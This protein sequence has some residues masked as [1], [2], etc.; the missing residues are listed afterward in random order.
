MSRATD[1]LKVKLLKARLEAAESLV[2]SFL[3][4]KGIGKKGKDGVEK[5]DI[6]RRFRRGAAA[7]LVGSGNDSKDV[8]FTNG[9]NWTYHN[10]KPLLNEAVQNYVV[11]LGYEPFSLVLCGTITSKALSRETRGER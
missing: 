11:K 7:A 9:Y 10:L 8:H 5:F 1:E 3:A 2:D 6:A 4:R